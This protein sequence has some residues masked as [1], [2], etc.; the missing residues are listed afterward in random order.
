M[1]RWQDKFTWNLILSPSRKNPAMSSVTLWISYIKCCHLSIYFLSSHPTIHICCCVYFV[2]ITYHGVWLT[3]CFYSGLYESNSKQFYS[4]LRCCNCRCWI[5]YLFSEYQLQQVFSWNLWISNIFQ[6]MWLLRIFAGFLPWDCV[7]SGRPLASILT[8]S[9]HHSWMHFTFHTYCAF[10]AYCTYFVY[11]YHAYIEVNVD[12][13]DMPYW[14][15]AHA[16]PG[17]TSH[18]QCIYIFHI[19]W[20]LYTFQIIHTSSISHIANV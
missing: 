11:L 20:I 18:T 19:L 8:T 7:E 12:I 16:A 1:G 14:P 4:W 2:L 9:P 5:P 6:N 10:C 3:S 15:P 17:C 13:S